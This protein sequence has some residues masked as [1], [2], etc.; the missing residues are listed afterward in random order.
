ML[1]SLIT[2]NLEFPQKAE[3]YAMAEEKNVIIPAH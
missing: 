2:G 1:I 3:E